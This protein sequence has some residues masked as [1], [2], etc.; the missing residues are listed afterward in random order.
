ME[1]MK[2]AG[3]LTFGEIM[4]KVKELRSQSDTEHTTSNM[5]ADHLASLP[6]TEHNTVQHSESS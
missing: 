5:L 6:N 2:E 4:Q 3:G 1:D